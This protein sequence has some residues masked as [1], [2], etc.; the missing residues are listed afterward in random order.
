MGVEV[1]EGGG[2]VAADRAL[3]R[4]ARPQVDRVYVAR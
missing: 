1:E 3:L 4:L 2:C